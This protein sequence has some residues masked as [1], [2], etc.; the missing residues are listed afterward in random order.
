[1]D[2][3]AIAKFIQ[4]EAVGKRP[5]NLKLSDI[6][7]KLLIRQVLR[8]KN[9]I[10]TGPS[11][12]GKTFA[13]QQVAEVLNR[14]L[15][16]FNLG[17]TQDPRSSLIGNTQFKDGEGTYFGESEFVRAIQ[18]ENAIVLLDELSR[19]HPEAWNILMSVT[20]QGQRYLRIDE[21][22]DT[23]TIKVAEGVTFIATANIGAEYT[24]ARVMDRAIMDRFTIVEME[25]LSQE[26]EEDLIKMLHPELDGS[27]A[28]AISSISSQTR[29]EVMTDN[30]N[31]SSSVSTRVALECAELVLDGF[32]LAEAAQVSIYPYFSDAGGEESERT[33][34][35]QVVEK[36]LPFDDGAEDLFEGVDEDDDEDNPF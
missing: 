5:A 7:W 24:S 23:P 2:T 30:G 31:I 14:P 10:M 15:F 11:G 3:N 29:Q 12:C 9:V 36:Y 16:S 13:T 8:G 17:A 18:T 4:D 21:A 22:P 32:S 26:D 28:K 35:R 1:M 34:V 27:I 25:T 20:D 33:W 19:A 6:K